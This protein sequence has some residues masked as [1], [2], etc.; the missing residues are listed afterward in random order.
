MWAVVS[1]ACQTFKWR[2][3]VAYW[4]ECKLRMKVWTRN[5][6]LGITDLEFFKVMTE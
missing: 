6:H 5:K 4:M 3:Q 2:C 1:W